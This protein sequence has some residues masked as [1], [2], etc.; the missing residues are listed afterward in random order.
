VAVG[1][2]GAPDLPRWSSITAE[3]IRPAITAAVDA[4]TAELDAI[5]VR[6]PRVPRGD[7]GGGVG[8]KGSRRLQSLF[9]KQRQ[10][11]LSLYEC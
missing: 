2:S 4:A 3:H 8:R 10:T 11:V 9:Q 1:K 5:E 6:V 7:G